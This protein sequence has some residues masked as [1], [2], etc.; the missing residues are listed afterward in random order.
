M[1]DLELIIHQIPD[2][3]IIVIPVSDVHLG[4]IEHN[5]KEWVDFCNMVKSSPSVYITLGGDLINNSVRNSVANPFDEVMRPREQKRRMVEHLTP[6]RD[7]I[8][9]AV[10]GNHEAR[11][12]KDTDMDITYDIMA[13]L[14]LE[15]RYRENAAFVKI[16]LGNKYPGKENDNSPRSTYVICVT[17]GAGGGIYTGATVNRNERFSHVVE[18]VDCFFVGHSH[19]G[20]VSRPAKIVVDK[21]NNKISMKSVVVVSSESW[22]NFGG[23]AMRKML[24]PSETCNPQKVVFKADGHKKNIKVIW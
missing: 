22:L 13:K 21:I 9:C 17:H 7:K 5:Y 23:Y 12:T 3:E 16:G 8:L 6:I 19:K 18:G 14:D 11:T 24:L 10:S 15:D 20:T 4:A 1:N 2:E